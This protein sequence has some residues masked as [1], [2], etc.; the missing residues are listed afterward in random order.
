ML[1][2]LTADQEFLRDT[3]ARFLNDR[4][5]PSALRSLRDDAAG[6]DAEYWRRGVE[7]GWTSLLVSEGHGGGSVSGRPMVDA[8]LI[9]YEFGLHAAPGPFLPCNLVASALSAAST[10]AGSEL[11]S[12]LLKGT[13]VAAWCFAE[14]H[15]SGHLPSGLTL[16]I[17]V[18]GDEVVVAG[19]KRPVESAGQASHL[20]VTGRTGEGLSQVLVPADT[21]GVTLRPMSSTDITRRFWVVSFDEVRVPTSALLGEAGGAEDEVRRQ[22][23]Q[24]LVLLCAESVGS[25]QAGFDMTSEWVLDRYSF[26]RPLASYQAL[27]HRFADM[28][29]W[30]EASHAIADAAAKAADSGAADADEL[31]SV[32]KAFVGDYGAEMLH[33]C[34]QMH[35][36]IG[37]TFEHDLHLFLRRVT[38]DRAL[39]GTPPDHRRLIADILE[40]SGAAA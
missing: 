37:V 18:E 33:D 10:D 35:G 32:A 6:Y 13:A 15:P 23:R 12:E 30:L 8:T 4:V 7:L 9:A 14:G 5:P 26:G 21:P 16:D 3:T 22:L 39:L 19:T 27:K 34:V 31:V 28:K 2:D 29:T 17:R 36:G 11:L 25:M 38:L 20:L 1:L 24:A 40:R